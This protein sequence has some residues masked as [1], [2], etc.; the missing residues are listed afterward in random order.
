VIPKAQASHIDA[1]IESLKRIQVRGKRES[2]EIAA[3]GVNRLETIANWME[4]KK[5]AKIQLNN[6]H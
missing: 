2:S 3:H 1:A 6:T 5:L 4:E